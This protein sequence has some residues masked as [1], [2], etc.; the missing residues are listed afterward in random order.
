MAIPPA[1]QRPRWSLH[2]IP[3]GAFRRELVDEETLHLVKAAGLV[4]HNAASYGRYL[5]GVFHDDAVFR[6][7]IDRWV[8]EEEQHGAA[9]RRWAEQADPTFDGGAALARFSDTVRLPE[10][11]SVSVRGSRLGELVARCTVEIGTATFYTALRES[12]VEPVLREICRRIAGDE[13]RHYRL[14][15]DHA[16]RYRSTRPRWRMLGVVLGRIADTGDD[17]LAFAWHASGARGRY[18]RRRAGAAFHCASLRR[19][20]ATHIQRA[21]RLAA[22][23]AGYAN[24]GWLVG[25]GASLGWRVLRRQL[26]W[27][28]K[29]AARE[30][31][32]RKQ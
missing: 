21:A 27:A 26:R 2:D 22:Q 5:H 14:F 29:W 8:A 31:T 9:L 16:R 32:P 25:L 13:A 7:V 11:A 23:A 28:G 3:W 30:P 20:R 12:V 10:G 15:L 1:A 4:E 24:D 18:R 19:Y 17:E 6:A